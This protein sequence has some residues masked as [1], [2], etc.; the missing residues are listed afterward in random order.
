M[1]KIKENRSCAA[2]VE[3]ISDLCT[4]L[5]NTVYSNDYLCIIDYIY[6]YIANIL[7]KGFLLSYVCLD[8]RCLPTYKG[9]AVTV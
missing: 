9:R 8:L 7:P 3:V 5:F 4:I 6:I 2:G 1:H